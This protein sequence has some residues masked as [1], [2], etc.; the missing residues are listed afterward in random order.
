[1]KKIITLTESDLLRIVKKVQR[2]SK[3]LNEWDDPD[4]ITSLGG[5]AAAGILYLSV[6]A[7]ERLW[8][9]LMEKNEARKKITFLKERYGWIFKGDQEF[10]DLLEKYRVLRDEYRSEIKNIEDEAN[11]DPFNEKT[12]LQKHFGAMSK[13]KTWKDL[14]AVSTELENYMKKRISDEFG[15]EEIDGFG[16]TFKLRS[17]RDAVLDNKIKI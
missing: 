16:N 2:E 9:W 4:L 8:G 12:P 15:S 13:S 11:Q 5:L 7:A 17:L 3:Q 10:K 6:D 14:D 1:M